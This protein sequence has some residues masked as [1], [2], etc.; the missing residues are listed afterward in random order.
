MRKAR[1]SRLEAAVIRNG[2]YGDRALLTAVRRVQAVV[3]DQQLRHAVVEAGIG[4]D[5]AKA[6]PF[7]ALYY[8]SGVTFLGDLVGGHPALVPFEDFAA[9]KEPRIVVVDRQPNRILNIRA[10]PD[11][12]ESAGFHIETA[13][14]NAGAMCVR[15]VGGRPRQTADED[16][17]AMRS[18]ISCHRTAPDQT[19]WKSRDA[20]LS[21]HRSQLKSGR[22]LC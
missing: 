3:C 6:R 19:N 5:A 20:F 2:E 4:G 15:E 16:E 18:G 17:I 12:N 8:M 1:G 22:F 21:R 7:A 11:L 13:D 10:G 14:R 9:G